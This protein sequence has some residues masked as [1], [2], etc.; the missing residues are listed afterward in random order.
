MMALEDRFREKL[1]E[2][3]MNLLQAYILLKVFTDPKRKLDAWERKELYRGLQ[4]I[5][6]GMEVD[7]L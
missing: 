2:L 6:L 3:D 5:L 7:K 4:I 1:G